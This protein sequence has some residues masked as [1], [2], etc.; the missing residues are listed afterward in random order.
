VKS[1]RAE[2]GWANQYFGYAHELFPIFPPK[3]RLCCLGIGGLFAAFSSWS[4]SEAGPSVWRGGY[5]LIVN[6]D[7]KTVS[8][9]IPIL[10][11]SLFHELG[12][13]AGAKFV[14]QQAQ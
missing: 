7:Q 2:T 4:W 1:N 13:R 14:E 5:L 8:K 3:D 9:L 6:S 10:L 12:A 11:Q